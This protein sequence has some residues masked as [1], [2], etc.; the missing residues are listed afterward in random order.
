[1]NGIDPYAYMQQVSVKMNEL[2]KR[3]ELETVLDELEYLFEV[4]P[5]E[6]QDNAETLIGLIREKLDHCG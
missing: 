2:T 4:I 5:P 3:D 1:M 6:M